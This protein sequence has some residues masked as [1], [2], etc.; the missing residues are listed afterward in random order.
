MAKNQVSFIFFFKS[1]FSCVFCQDLF[2]DFEKE[3]TARRKQGV[4]DLMSYLAIAL[5]WQGSILAV[6]KMN[7]ISSG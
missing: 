7:S 2:S 6:K 4:S 3:T 5:T 1:V